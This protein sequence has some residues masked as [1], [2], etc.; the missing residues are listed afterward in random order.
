MRCRSTPLHTSLLLTN[1]LQAFIGWL[2]VF[3]LCAL[4]VDVPRLR[5][6]E[7]PVAEARHKPWGGSGRSVRARALHAGPLLSNVLDFFSQLCVELGAYLRRVT[8]GQ[9][10]VPVSL[11]PPPTPSLHSDFHSV[12]H[13]LLAALPCSEVVTTNYDVLFE[14]AIKASGACMP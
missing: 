10:L 9:A 13:S 1:P 8:C 14:Q 5:V 7:Q 2:L 11:V 12:A 3:S 4:G 6:S